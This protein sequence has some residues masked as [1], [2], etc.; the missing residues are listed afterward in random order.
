MNYSPAPASRAED[1]SHN[2]D[3]TYGG[4]GVNCCLDP[5]LSYIV[6]IIPVHGRE[7]NILLGL[8]TSPWHCD[9]HSQI[10]YRAYPTVLVSC[11]G[12]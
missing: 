11:G 10:I 4:S 2:M 8:S 3:I 7:R 12:A 6:F 5:W 1:I 9:F